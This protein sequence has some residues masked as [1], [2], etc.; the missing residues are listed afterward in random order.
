MNNHDITELQPNGVVKIIDDNLKEESDILKNLV[1]K[2]FDSNVKVKE[3][4]LDTLR[5]NENQLNNVITSTDSAQNAMR[6]TSKRQEREWLSAFGKSQERIFDINS[7]DR[8]YL[9]NNI[10]ESYKI[11]S[12]VNDIESITNQLIEHAEDLNRI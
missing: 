10:K 6:N 12:F 7:R 3:K 5:D 9:I 1:E 8:F 4:Y 11:D 2:V